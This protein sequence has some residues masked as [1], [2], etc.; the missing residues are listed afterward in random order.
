MSEEQS[1]DIGVT[2]ISDDQVSAFFENNGE[3]PVAKHE[4]VEPEV[5]QE[6]PK[7]E[8][9]EEPKEEP[10]EEP[11]EKYVPLAALHEE[12]EKRKELKA[13][14]EKMEQLFQQFQQGK[15]QE[16][17]PPITFEDD[18]F[19]YLKQEVQQV[20]TFADE[21]K[22]REQVT[23]DFQGT[24]AKY[25]ESARQFAAQNTDFQEAYRH[26]TLS[27]MAEYQEAGYSAE[28]ANHLAQQDEMAIVKKALA[29]DINPAE[30]MYKLAKLRGYS[31]KVEAPAEVPKPQPKLDTIEKG[32]KASQSL[33]NKGGAS[34][35]SLSLEDLADMDPNSEDFKK[36]WKQLIG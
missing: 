30:R 28:E 6:A 24:I 5:K 25:T 36:G 15:Q 31:K 12:R 19:E 9:R 21:Q 34:P 35:K 23:S 14:I 3:M 18:P 26:L 2:D 17:K 7:E 22:Q 4:T 32:V 8:P 13:K 27:R 11:K 20:K 29:D 16:Q 10:R 33:S 1:A